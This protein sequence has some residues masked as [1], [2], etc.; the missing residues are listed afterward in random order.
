[1]LLTNKLLGIFSGLLEYSL[2]VLG[3]RQATAATHI[4]LTEYV[5]LWGAALGPR[6]L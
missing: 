4:V 2:H 1:M 6:I 3:R 5:V